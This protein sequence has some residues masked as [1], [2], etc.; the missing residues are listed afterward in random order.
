MPG[1]FL[2]KW[3]IY[4]PKPDVQ[5]WSTDGYAS[6]E[7][8]G[9]QPNPDNGFCEWYNN[10]PDGSSYPPGKAAHIALILRAD[11]QLCFLLNNGQYLEYSIQMFPFVSTLESAVG[12]A[13][14]G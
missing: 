14:P 3:T 9:G 4:I 2:G 12:F 13:F 8:S 11:G 7:S 10:S 1:T 6:Y 5:Y